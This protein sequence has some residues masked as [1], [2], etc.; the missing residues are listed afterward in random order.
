MKYRY[1]FRAQGAWLKEHGSRSMAQGA[2][3]KGS[4][5]AYLYRLKCLEGFP[6]HFGP[7]SRSMAHWL[8]VLTD[9]RYL[10][11]VYTLLLYNFY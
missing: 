10:T 4:A 6:V 8:T 3:L 1:S 9:Y 2:W 5:L 11:P 7:G